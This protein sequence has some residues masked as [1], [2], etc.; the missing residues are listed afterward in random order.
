MDPTGDMRAAVRTSLVM[1]CGAG[2]L[3][4]VC[5]CTPQGRRFS[6]W[7]PRPA[8]ARPVV[9]RHV[10]WWGPAPGATVPPQ[11]EVVLGGLCGVQPGDALEV[12][13]GAWQDRCVGRVL[14]H[15][16]ERGGVVR[17]EVGG[18]S[19]TD[20]FNAFHMRGTAVLGQV[21]AIRLVVARGR[22]TAHKG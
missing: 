22:R 11:F 15:G 7:Q 6:G 13:R 19:G 20:C 21:T 1:M 12:H 9:G 16:C 5:T 8:G 14:L 18:P 10:V 3:L 17:C 2:I 4:A